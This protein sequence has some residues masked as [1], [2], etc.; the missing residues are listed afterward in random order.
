MNIQTN[1]FDFA[2]MASWFDSLD[3]LSRMALPEQWCFSSPGKTGANT[4][5]P[6]LERYIKIIFHKQAIAYNAESGRT[7]SNHSCLSAQILSG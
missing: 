3:D 7:R 6:I 4:E 5:F 1:L 2:Y